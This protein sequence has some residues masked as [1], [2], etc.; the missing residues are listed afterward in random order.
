MAVR[1]FIVVLKGDSCAVFEAGGNER[2]CNPGSRT[3][4][5]SGR[6]GGIMGVNDMKNGVR[7]DC[8]CR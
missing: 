6:S 7:F 1:K 3:W 2:L 5:G 8:F 4:L